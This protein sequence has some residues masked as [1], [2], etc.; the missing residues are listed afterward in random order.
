MRRPRI[1]CCF[2]LLLCALVGGGSLSVATAPA[3]RTTATVYPSEALKKR[4]AGKGVIHIATD[5][6]GFVTE[7]HME[8]STG[9]KLLDEATINTAR[10]YWQ[11]PP[12][13]AKSLPIEYRLS[14]AGQKGPVTTG[15]AG[16]TIPPIYYPP[17]AS[18]VYEQGIG[19]VKATTDEKGRVKEAVMIRSTGQAR[20]DEDAVATAKRKWRGPASSSLAIAIAYRMPPLPPDHKSISSKGWHT[21]I[22][23]YPFNA[24]VDRNRG[25]GIVRVST[26]AR[27]Q[28]VRASMIQPTGAPD[29]DENTVNFALAHWSGPPN[30]V[31]RVP[32]TYLLN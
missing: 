4:I 15:H 31:C 14:P 32:I 16:W 29:L 12:N 30:S 27:G 11:G 6:D 10:T 5:K 13:A 8:Q 22:P 19:T 25:S 28:V 21:P 1:V 23:F 9:S 2:S 17:D 24:R 7:A 3:W 26:D 20:L 18:D